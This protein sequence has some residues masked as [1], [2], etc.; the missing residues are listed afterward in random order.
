M[1]GKLLKYDLKWVY[2][3]I[4][5][6]Y[7]LAICFALIG[8][9]FSFLDDIV[10]FD[11]ISSFSCGV[12]VAMMF[13]IVINNIVRIWVRYIHNVYK[14]ESYL[15]HT[16]PVSKNDIFLS[17]IFTALITFF[18]SI[19]VVVI[20]F[21]ICFLNKEFIDFFKLI[22]ADVSWSVIILTSIVVILE[23]LF[24]IFLGIL[25]ITIGYKCNHNKLMK[26][27]VSGLAIYMGSSFASLMIL[28]IIGLFNKDV[29][30]LFT[31]INAIPSIDILNY[32]LVI[33]AIL[34]SVYII[35]CTIIGNKLFNKGVNV[36]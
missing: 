21:I 18:T 16:L 1:L 26:S 24:L 19:V 25:A 9:G 3:L 14:D 22:L 15:T 30:D 6:Y 10:I 2:K 35:L 13:N 28:F 23:F 8:R 34:Y 20:S 33:A 17:K 11:F 29:L 36:D 7:G 27:F 4:A 31:N 32:M 5:I 12:S